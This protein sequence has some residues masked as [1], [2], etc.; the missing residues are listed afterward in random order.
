M[1]RWPRTLFGGNVLLLIALIV[2]SQASTVA[3][4]LILVQYPRL[5]DAASVEVS[6]IVLIE[7]MVAM[8]PALQRRQWLMELHAVPQSALPADVREGG[9]PSTYIARR[10]FKLVTSELPTGLDVR[11]SESVGHRIWMR[12]SFDSGHRWIPLPATSIADTG[13]S[14]SAV[15]SLLTLAAFP[16]LGAHL[17]HRRIAAPL[18]RLSHAAASVERGV[19]PDAV[20]ADGP[21]KLSSVTVTFNRMM[22]SLAEFEATR[23]EMLAGISHDIRTPLTK[24]R[25]ALGAPETL[26]AP[27][28]TAERFIDEIDVTIQQFVDF[29]RGGESE[30]PIMGDLNALI[31]QLAADYAGLGHVFELELRAFPEFPFRPISVQRLLMNL[32]QNAVTYGRVGLS[33]TTYDEDGFV[34][35]CVG[36][37]GPGEPQESLSSLKQLFRRGTQATE[38]GTGL[39]LAIVERIARQHGGSLDLRL[40]DGGG[41][42]AEVKLLAG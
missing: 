41:F 20:P 39:G 3:I 24:L 19:W 29:G 5:E 25:M 18:E 34:V 11:W 7:R 10:W 32:M 16:A 2:A 21:L 23:A 30:G 40:R 38:K 9:I 1:R 42:I 31:G 35:I 6:Q 37:R 33:V 4:F 13:V 15:C 17:I 14:W 27:I 22:A 28:L 36:D 12:V 26:D 8:L